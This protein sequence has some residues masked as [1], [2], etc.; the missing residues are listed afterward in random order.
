MFAEVFGDA[1]GARFHTFVT[2]V[3][4]R[5]TDFAV[6]VGEEHG[7][8][9][10]D[11][12]VDV[13]AQR[14]VIDDRVA[15]CT[16]LVDKERTA[17]RYGVAEEHVVVFGDLLRKVRYERETYLADT[18]LVDCRVFPREVAELGVYG[19]T[20]HL[21]AAARELVETVV[22]SD[23]LGRTDEGEVQR[24]EEK[25]RTVLAEVLVEVEVVDDLVVSKYRRC[26]KIGGLVGD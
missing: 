20:D 6:L 12:F 16:V 24:V 15:Y 9:H 3:P 7:V 23:D 4:A 8:D 1:F 25:N 5:R 19:D 10:T 17:K 21:D 22:E 2:F 13:A 18:A 26:R 11:H 14:K